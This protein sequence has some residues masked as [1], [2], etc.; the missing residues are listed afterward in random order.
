MGKEIL[1]DSIHSVKKEYYQNYRKQ[2][3]EKYKQAQKKFW[4]KKLKEKQENQNKN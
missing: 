1:E 2:H 4:Q 3:P